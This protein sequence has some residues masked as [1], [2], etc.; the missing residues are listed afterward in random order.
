MIYE[1]VNLDEIN[2]DNSSNNEVL[3]KQQI[4]SILNKNK[5]IYIDKIIEEIDINLKKNYLKYNKYNVLLKQFNINYFDPIINEIKKKL[6]D[7]DSLFNIKIQSGFFSKNPTMYIKFYDKD[8]YSKKIIN[9]FNKKL[10]K[11]LT[12]NKDYVI[13]DASDVLSQH[14]FSATCQKRNLTKI[15]SKFG[16]DFKI[17]NYGIIENY[18][19]IYCKI[20]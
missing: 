18:Y 1:T 8:K 17:K 15:L 13:F 14:L 11:A 12:L 19:Y 10:N 4:I 20:K 3:S 6:F 16:Y 5:D 7:T 9:L 2:I